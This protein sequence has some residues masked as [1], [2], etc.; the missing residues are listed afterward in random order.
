MADKISINNPGQLPVIIFSCGTYKQIVV[1]PSQTVEIELGQTK[2]ISPEEQA[3]YYLGLNGFQGLT[4]NANK[5]QDDN[6]TATIVN[7]EDLPVIIF[8]CGTYKQMVIESKET[9]TLS[10]AGKPAV[11]PYEEKIYYM[12]LNGYQG[13]VIEEVEETTG[14]IKVT[15][16]KAED[17]SPIQG[18]TIT[19]TGVT[20]E[21]TGSDGTSTATDVAAGNVTLTIAASGYTSKEQEVTVTAGETAEQTVKLTVSA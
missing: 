17:D 5:G 16:L 4:V 18:A 12:N 2:L 13:L 8:E 21:A 11:S 19:G 1:N 6:Y 7:N 10:L 14:S 15:V 9:T 3:S 20:F